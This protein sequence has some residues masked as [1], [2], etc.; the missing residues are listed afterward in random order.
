MG[1]NIFKQSNWKR[2]NLQNINSLCSSV[3]KKKMVK[4]L[5]KHFSKEDIYMANKLMKRCSHHHIR[6]MQME[7]T[8]EDHLSEVRMAIIKNL[9][10]GLLW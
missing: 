9:Q 8:V 4:D 6:E 5:N 3:S 10:T 7:T 2:I 1:E